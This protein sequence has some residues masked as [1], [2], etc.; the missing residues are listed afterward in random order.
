MTYMLRKTKQKTLLKTNE[1]CSCL[2]TQDV[3]GYAKTLAEQGF[4]LTHWEVVRDLWMDAMRSSPYMEAYE[5]QNMGLGTA[6][7]A[8]RFFE[9]HVL[10]PMAEAI[11]EMEE[12]YQDDTNA[13][14][15]CNLV[16]WRTLYPAPANRPTDVAPHPPRFL[17]CCRALFTS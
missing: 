12:V 7:A 9:L 15:V 16:I 4:L 3:V 1:C 6:S 2:S 14:L 8:Y 5:L 11:A 10:R 17:F 13:Q